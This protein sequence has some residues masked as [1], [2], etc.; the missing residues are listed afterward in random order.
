VDHFKLNISD[1]QLRKPEAE[2]RR[3]EGLGGGDT[4]LGSDSGAGRQGSFG[5]TGVRPATE[6]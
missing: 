3:L 6:K 4:Q 1:A 5:G 2:K